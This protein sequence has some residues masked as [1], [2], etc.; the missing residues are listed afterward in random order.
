MPIYV[1]LVN[2]FAMSADRGNSFVEMFF[3]IECL[4]RRLSDAVF[5]SAIVFAVTGEPFEGLIVVFA[6][7]TILSLPIREDSTY[8]MYSRIVIGVYVVE[9]NG[10][11]PTKC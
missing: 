10:H 1:L 3:H 9:S 5:A 6:H 2:P 8:S 11:C 7:Q 4:R